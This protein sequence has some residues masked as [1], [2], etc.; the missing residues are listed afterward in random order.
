M[1]L[2][3]TASGRPQPSI[4]RTAAGEA[5]IKARYEHDLA[6][7]AFPVRRTVLPTRY[8]ETHLL[9]A[10]P[11]GAQ[12]IL[13][14]HGGNATNPLTLAWF[15]PL[16][17]RFRIYA[18]DTIGHP[19]LSA[20][21]RL[22]PRDDSYGRWA[23]DLLDALDLERAALVG[24]SYGAGIILRAAA[25]APERIS[26]A[27]LIVPSGI[28]LGPLAPMLRRIILPLLAYRLR[29]SRKALRRAVQPM[30]TEAVAEPALDT[31]EAVY[32]HVRLEREL[33]RLATA[34]ELARFSAPTLLLAAER[35]IFFPA[36]SV[37]PRARAIIPNLVA[38]ETLPGSGH[39]PSREGI[40]QINRDIMRL[41]ERR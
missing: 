7:L 20:Q 28:A 34:D 6:Q 3:S 11:E 38:A 17:E 30:F 12:P 26:H 23:V 19:G 37:L 18:P 9:S 8:G 5:A 29:P 24:P 14:F 10:G 25:L 15:R 1:S 2:L 40:A 32:R 4:Y 31:L 21:T 36:A 13:L 22:S 35:D 39:F 16:T 33:P 41:L 27:A